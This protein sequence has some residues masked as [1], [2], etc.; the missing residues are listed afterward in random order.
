ML[1]RCFNLS[2]LKER[3]TKTMA[4]WDKPVYV[5]SCLSRSNAD[6]FTSKIPEFK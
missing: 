5:A 3:R 1:R 4:S 6:G 2:V